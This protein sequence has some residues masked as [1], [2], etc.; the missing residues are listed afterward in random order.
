MYNAA[1]YGQLDCLKYL[2]EEAL[3]PLH[4]WEDI[5]ALVTN[6]PSAKTTCSKKGLQNQQT[7]NTQDL[8]KDCELRKRTPT[9]RLIEDS[10]IAERGEREKDKKA[11][12]IPHF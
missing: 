7:Y 2:V 11:D 4:D 12:L 3:S 6:N 10:L 8:S 9:M 1:M 5:A